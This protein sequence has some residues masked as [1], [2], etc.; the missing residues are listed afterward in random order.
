MPR[1]FRLLIARG[2]W[3]AKDQRGRLKLTAKAGL[4]LFVAVALH[5]FLAY[6]LAWMVMARTDAWLGTAAFAGFLFC[7]SFFYF[8]FF[9][10]ALI[11][12]WPL[13]ASAKS[14]LISRARRRLKALPGL[15]IIA[16]AGSY[17]KTTAKSALAKVL[18]QK[19]RVAATADSINTPLGIAEFIRHKISA[20]TEFAVIE[21]GEHYPGDI[22]ELCGII[23]PDIGVITGINESHLERMGSL[24][25]IIGTVFEL[26]D[27]VKSGGKLAIN[28]DD[29]N[30]RDNY[31]AYMP[32]GNAL[33]YSGENDSRF[34][35]AIRNFSFDEQTLANSFDLE[36]GGESAR[37]SSRILGGYIRQIAGLCAVVGQLAGLNLA[38]IAAGIS[39]IEP[40]KHRLEPIMNSRGLL[41]I[42]DGYN[43]NPDGVREAINLLMKFKS[44]RKVFV[45]PGLVELGQSSPEI[46]REIGRQLA[47]A[48]DLAILIK[49][50]VTPYIEEGFLG[51]GGDKSKIAWFDTAPEAHKQLGGL[52]KPNDVILFQNDWGDQYI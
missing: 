13:Q 29:K 1:Y 19:Y 28:I 24:K 21:L 40:V 14:W 11:I 52:L 4:L 43:G 39:S 33:F 8:I 37:V 46:H 17:G 50:S 23:K 49:N 48:A 38:Q 6:Q 42:D 32:A 7:G 5:A 3:P 20:E 30:V 9:S 25:A 31:A 16:V 15:K 22:R 36:L 12:I 35:G 51:A 34:A 47:S 10:I 26:A 41:I 45:T 2:F 44:R 18:E 27:G